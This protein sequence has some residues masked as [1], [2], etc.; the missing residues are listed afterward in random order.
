MGNVEFIDHVGQCFSAMSMTAERWNGWV[1]DVEGTLRDIKDNPEQYEGSSVPIK[2]ICSEKFRHTLTGI[3]YWRSWLSYMAA[4][5]RYHNKRNMKAI[6]ITEQEV[7]EFT[8]AR[9]QGNEDLKNAPD[10]NDFYSN[11]ILPEDLTSFREL[12]EELERMKVEKDN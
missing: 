9:Q 6:G 2:C 11:K 8:D 4:T 1:T 10:F 3:R 12:D 5:M 7:M